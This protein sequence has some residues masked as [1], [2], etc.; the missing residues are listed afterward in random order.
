VIKELDL[1]ALRENLPEHGLVAGDVGTV[2]MVHGE[3][4]G[5]EV[6][7]VTSAGETVAVLSLYADQVR[8][9]AGREILHARE[10]IAV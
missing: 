3:G 5:Y 10:L 6:E 7:F 4:K 9:L 8:A 2:V 1:V